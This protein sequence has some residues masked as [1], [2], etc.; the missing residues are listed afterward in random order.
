LWAGLAS[1]ANVNY[2]GKC[3]FVWVLQKRL[4]SVLSLVS[5]EN[6]QQLP[7]WRVLALDKLA[8]LAK[9]PETAMN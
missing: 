3:E 1:T 4:A 9:Q 7:F 6:S 5:Q 8:T 2:F